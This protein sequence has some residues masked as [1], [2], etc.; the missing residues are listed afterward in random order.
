MLLTIYTMV[1][2]SSGMHCPLNME[3]TGAHRRMSL[4]RER[5]TLSVLYMSQDNIGVT[6]CS[7]AECRAV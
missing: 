7:Q 1:H 4:S 2:Q 6:V 5:A 3:T